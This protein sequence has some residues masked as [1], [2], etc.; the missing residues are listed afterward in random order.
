MP[1]SLSDTGAPQF[2]H[3]VIW[4]VSPTFV[5]T[6]WLRMKVQ[7]S[8]NGWIVLSPLTIF[9]ASSTS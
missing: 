5:F 8:V 2:G 3:C 6:V 7:N 1:D 9:P 4:A